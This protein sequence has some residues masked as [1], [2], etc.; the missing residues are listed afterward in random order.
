MTC[1]RLLAGPVN[2]PRLLV[3]SGPGSPGPKSGPGRIN[4]AW[5]FIL[6]NAAGSDC[7]SCAFFYGLPAGSEDLPSGVARARAASRAL[8]RFQQKVRHA[9]SCL[10]ANDVT[11]DSSGRGNNTVPCRRFPG[12]CTGK[13]WRWATQKRW[14]CQTVRRCTASATYRRHPSGPVCC[15][16]LDQPALSGH[17]GLTL[18]SMPLK[19]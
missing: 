19:V 10:L 12:R 17:P 2:P 4:R 18:D 6:P 7:A 3:S 16:V 1:A 9:R 5:H 11:G 8:L 13:D 14:C 15:P